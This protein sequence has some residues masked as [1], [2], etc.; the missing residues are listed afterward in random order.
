MPITAKQC[1]CFYLILFTLMLLLRAIL[2]G[3]FSLALVWSGVGVDLAVAVVSIFVYWFLGLDWWVY[4]V[5]ISK[6]INICFCFPML[7]FLRGCLIFVLILKKLCT[8]TSRISPHYKRLVRVITLN[9]NLYNLYTSIIVILCYN[10]WYL[11]F[12]HW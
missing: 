7:P 4:L 9:Y 5:G 11:L 1:D 12:R 8:F 2:G 6:L 10:K 3:T